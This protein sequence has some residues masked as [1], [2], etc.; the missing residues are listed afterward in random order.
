[1]RRLWI[2]GLL[3]ALLAFGEYVLS[4]GHEI[5]LPRVMQFDANELDKAFECS[6]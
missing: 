2:I 1:M 4:N 6:Q 5:T 3:C